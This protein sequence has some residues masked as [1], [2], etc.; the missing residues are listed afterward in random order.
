[1]LQT[2]SLLPHKNEC[3]RSVNHLWH[4]IIGNPEGFAAT[5]TRTRTVVRLSRQ[6]M[7]VT[8]AGICPKHERHQMVNDFWPCNNA[9]AE[10]AQ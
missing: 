5:L 8:T 10:A 7:V 3:Q 9:N 1:M 4:C 2:I 6:H